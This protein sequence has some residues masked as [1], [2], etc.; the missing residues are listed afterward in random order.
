[1]KNNKTVTS[2]LSTTQ[3]AQRLGLS[4]GTIQ[5]MVQAGVLQ[6]YTTQGGHRRILASSLNHYS[7]GASGADAGPRLLCVLSASRDTD[8]PAQ[9]LELPGVHMVT[10]PL[11]LAGMRRKVDAL[12]MDARIAWLSWDTLD[13][14]HSLGTQAHCIIYNS[15]HLPEGSRTRLQAQAS[16][17]EGDISPDLI[18]GYLLGCTAPALPTA[19][20]TAS[21]GPDRHLSEPSLTPSGQDLAPHS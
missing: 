7:Q 15:G 4:V 16:L 13:I 21:S 8:P 5:R 9:W 14:A 3:A 11:A 20:P 6:A 2:Y 19:R 12:F 10:N 17:Y 1:M 18:Q